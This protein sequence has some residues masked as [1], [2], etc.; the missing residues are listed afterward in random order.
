MKG[1]ANE[2]MKNLTLSLPIFAILFAWRKVDE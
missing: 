2:R 1:A